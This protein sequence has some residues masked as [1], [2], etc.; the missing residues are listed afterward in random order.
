MPERYDGVFIKNIQEKGFEDKP[1]L[2]HFINDFGVIFIFILISKTAHVTVD[3][4]W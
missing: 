2:D 4:L 1:F 3:L